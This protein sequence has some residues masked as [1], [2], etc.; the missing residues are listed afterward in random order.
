[1]RHVAGV[2]R[3]AEL[4]V[5]LV[6]DVV[7]VQIGIVAVPAQ[8]AERGKIVQ[9][10]VFGEMRKADLPLVALAEGGDEEQVVRG[11]TTAARPCLPTRAS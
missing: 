6:V 4:V 1:M 7:E 3:P 5:Q 2:F 9:L 11:S 10:R 8:H